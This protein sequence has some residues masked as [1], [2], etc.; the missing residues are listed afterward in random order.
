MFSYIVDASLQLLCGKGAPVEELGRLEGRSNV[1]K[2]MASDSA[3]WGPFE[4]I[5]SLVNAVDSASWAPFERTEL[6]VNAVGS[7]AV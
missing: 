2:G 1:T 6:L 3:P 5:E 7:Q 4:R